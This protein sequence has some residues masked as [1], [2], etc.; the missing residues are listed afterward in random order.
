VIC[1]PIE[2]FWGSVFWILNGFLWLSMAYSNFMI[3]VFLER[4]KFTWAY[5]EF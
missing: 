3:Q 1:V 4:E 2:E 5:C